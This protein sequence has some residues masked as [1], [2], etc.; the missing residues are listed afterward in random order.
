MPEVAI[1][2]DNVVI[3]TLGIG[4]VFLGERLEYPPEYLLQHLSVCMP[5][6]I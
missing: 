2:T 4:I 3:P 6:L 5:L 1:C